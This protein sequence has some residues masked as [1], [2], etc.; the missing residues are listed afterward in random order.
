MSQAIQ[1][2]TTDYTLSTMKQK[3]TKKSKA[4]PVTKREGP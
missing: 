2:P 3:E 4:I 1:T